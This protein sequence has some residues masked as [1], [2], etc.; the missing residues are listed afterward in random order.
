MPAPQH[1][2]RTHFLLL[3]PPIAG[4]LAW[5]GG[6]VGAFALGAALVGGY[7]HAVQQG[8]IQPL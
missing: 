4:I 6:V 5:V 7:Q 8:W 2:E 3:N 1:A